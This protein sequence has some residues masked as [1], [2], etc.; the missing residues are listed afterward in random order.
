LE[1]RLQRLDI[2]AADRR[3]GRLWRRLKTVFGEKHLDRMPDAIGSHVLVFSTV[4]G[5]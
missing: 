5:L 4:A 2:S 1:A 3:S